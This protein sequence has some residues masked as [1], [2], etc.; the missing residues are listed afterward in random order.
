[1]SIREEIET[2][3]RTLAHSMP[4]SD[5]GSTRAINGVVDLILAERAD[6]AEKAAPALYEASDRI[7][8]D[9]LAQTLHAISPRAGYF[10][11]DDLAAEE[12][13][14]RRAEAAKLRDELFNDGYSIVRQSREG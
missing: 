3:V 11:W 13:D 4:P 2:R 9:K 6:A 7:S 5:F 10:G 1:M 12:R 14:D 8:T